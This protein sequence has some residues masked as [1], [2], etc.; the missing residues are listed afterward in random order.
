MN[1]IVSITPTT[2]VEAYRAA[3]DAASLCKEIVL[4][5][6]VEIQ[7]RRYVPVEGWQSVAV[8][9]GCAASSRDVERV[10][11]GYRAIGEVRRMSDGVVIAEAEGFVGEDEPTWF[12]GTVTS[13][14]KSKTLPKRADYAIRAMTQTR[15]ISRACRSAFAHVVVMMNAGLATTPAEEVPYGGFDNDA[16]EVLEGTPQPRKSIAQARKDGDFERLTAGL[17]ACKTEA[18]LLLWAS[19][20]ADEIGGLPKSWRDDLRT[21]YG[22]A[23]KAA[24]AGDA[25]RAADPSGVFIEPPADD[26]DVEAWNEWFETVLRCIMGA[27]TEAEALDAMATNSASIERAGLLVPD[28]ESR[29]ADICERRIAELTAKAA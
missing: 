4:R 2:N 26:A 3:T 27:T 12:G 7:G 13:Y 10:D 16:G 11:G 19:T 20:S 1:Q 18:D 9:H 5:S 28:A 23:L 15:A 6:A 8:A 29:A 24:R 21:E 25:A 22:D 14:G 17:R